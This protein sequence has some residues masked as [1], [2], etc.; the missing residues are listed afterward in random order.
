MFKRGTGRLPAV[1]RTGDEPSRKSIP[2]PGTASGS[3]AG[4]GVCSEERRQSAPS[5][6]PDTVGKAGLHIPAPRTA[7]ESLGRGVHQDLGFG[8]T[9]A[10]H[11]MISLVP[12]RVMNQNA[13]CVIVLRTERPVTG[14][15]HARTHTRPHTRTHSTAHSGRSK[16]PRQLVIKQDR[17]C[18]TPKRCRSVAASRRTGSEASA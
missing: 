6:A 4:P 13:S 7:W 12:G 5:Q 2:A 1:Q 10:S 16:N 15:P 17:A 9:P 8:H 11:P 3:V 14:A 18:P